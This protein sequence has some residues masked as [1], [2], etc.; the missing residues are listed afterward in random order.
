M[1][2]Q[3][4]DVDT[5]FGPHPSQIGDFSIESLVSQMRR[6]GISYSMAY[7]LRGVIYN[8][9]A[10]NDEV[11]KMAENHPEILPVATLDPRPYFGV[12]E[13]AERIAAGP[14]V[15][16]RLLPEQQG[17]SVDSAYFRK[18]LKLL[19]GYG[20]PIIIAAG[21]TG[22]CTKIA[23]CTAD[24]SIPI[25]L[26]GATYFSWG[27]VME[28]AKIAP[29]ILI[30]TQMLDVPYAPEIMAEE[31]GVDRY[32]FGSSSPAA[33]IRPPLSILLR[34]S[35]S[36]EDKEKI[37]SGNIRRALEKR[38]PNLDR[39]G[40]KDAYNQWTIDR[41]IID[42][43]CHEGPWPF[44]MKPDGAKGI[45]ELMRKTGIEK[46][47]LSSAEALVSDFVHGNKEMAKAIEGHPE[48]LGYVTVNP[49]YLEQ[50]C[51]EMDT[52][53]SMPNF[54]GVKVHPGYC[55]QSINSQLTKA[56][57]KE[58][59]KRGVPL[60][61]HTMGFGEPA[62]VLDLAQHVSNLPILMGHGG[63]NA[64]RESLEVLGRTSNVYTEFCASFCDRGKVEETIKAVGADRVLFGSDMDLIA[65]EYILGMYEEAGMSAEEQDKVMYENV[66]QLFGI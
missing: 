27:E 30:S 20:I 17:W 45:L 63:S 52:Y 66:A 48:L 3:V 19:D 7:S 51:A 34:S 11:L 36:D 50:S 62:K 38:R 23:Q 21:G 18:L 25:I 65:P 61:I 1:N 54:V 55:G 26:T 12:E 39:Q 33:Y 44:P 59:E 32:V 41:P 60:L 57:A 47:I 10:A 31:L 5:H 22:V 64:W 37:L 46:C 16:C 4:I 42:A 49:N 58:V 9:R 28:A 56:L 13:E 53:L 24:L 6:Q 8:S 29:N 14:F 15:A 40:D 35:L 43:H 2:F